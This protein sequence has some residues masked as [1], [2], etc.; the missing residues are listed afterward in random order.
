MGEEKVLVVV[1]V[2]VLPEHRRIFVLCIT[3]LHRLRMRHVVVVGNTAILGNLAMACG[4]QEVQLILVADIGTEQTAVE[5]GEVLVAEVA[6]GVGIVEVEAYV[7]TL[8][9]IDRELRVDMIF[10]V[11]L[12]A[13]VI[14]GDIRIGRQRVHKQE[15]LGAFLR[16]AVRLCEDVVIGRHRAVDENTT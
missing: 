4:K 12:V 5:V 1:T 6:S 3:V 7:Q 2:P 16:V 13:A 14:V 15:L 9:R 11:G 8:A 10:T